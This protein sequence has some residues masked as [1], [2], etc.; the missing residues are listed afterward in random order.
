MTPHDNNHLLDATPPATTGAQRSGGTTI[1]L[2]DDEPSVRFIGKLMLERMGFHVV[3]AVDGNDAI[4][5]FRAGETGQ[6][7]YID[8]VILDA[9]MPE[10]NGPETFQ[11]I[12]RIR[13]DVPVI[14]SSGYDRQELSERFG[15]HSFSGFV[16]KPY[17]VADLTNTLKAVLHL[18][19]PSSHPAPT[20][21]T[22]SPLQPLHS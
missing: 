16:P 20:V 9:T 18:G 19:H 15:D 21:T 17:R 2:A 22:A 14:L 6:A 11:E 10:K 12:R 5:H 4:H 1:L 8:C 7:A 3:L 13:H